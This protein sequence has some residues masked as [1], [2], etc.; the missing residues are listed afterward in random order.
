MAAGPSVRRLD[1][2][3]GDVD[4]LE[5]RVMLD[6]GPPVLAAES[7]HLH[8]AERQLDGS[9]VVVVDPAGAGLQAGNH[10]VS[11]AEI[12]GEDSGRQA[13]LAGVGARY[14]LVFVAELEH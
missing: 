2:A 3:H 14:H 9:H 4:A 1:V 11:A 7:R 6:G 12:T 10:P 5:L 13:K 8:A